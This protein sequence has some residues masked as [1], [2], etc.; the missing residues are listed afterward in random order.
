[1]D[2]GGW[3]NWETFCDIID[4]FTNDPDWSDRRNK[5]KALRE[6]LRQGPDQ[7]GRYLKSG[8]MRLPGI[9]GYED[10]PS[11]GWQGGYCGYFDAIE[12][13]DDF[14]RLGEGRN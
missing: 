4:H 6:V 11:R 12:A 13:M 3:R 9:P 10:M 2:K 7:T 5:V 8:A 14:V 1:M